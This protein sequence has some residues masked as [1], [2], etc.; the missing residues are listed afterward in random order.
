MKADTRRTRPSTTVPVRPG[1]SLRWRPLI[2]AVLMTAG[3]QGILA[4]AIAEGG[5]PLLG[6]V[7]AVGLALCGLLLILAAVLQSGRR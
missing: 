1:S 3:A 2:F 7:A 5:D 6:V 4:A